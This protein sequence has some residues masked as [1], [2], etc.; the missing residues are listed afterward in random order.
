MSRANVNFFPNLT[1]LAIAL[2]SSATNVRDAFVI[3]SGELDDLSAATIL[4]DA[5]E[6]NPLPP[7]KTGQ[8][9]ASS[10]RPPINCYG[11]TSSTIVV[12][13]C[14]DRKIS[15]QSRLYL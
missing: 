10:S 4:R 14:I 11:I 6:I 7:G 3:I 1:Q 8:I 12:A 9:E 15:A 13:A 2:I 5:G